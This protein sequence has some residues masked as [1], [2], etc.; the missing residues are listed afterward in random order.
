ML[1]LS[2]YNFFMIKFGLEKEAVSNKHWKNML[3]TRQNHSAAAKF[4]IL[5]GLKDKKNRNYLLSQNLQK[6]PPEVF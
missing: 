1:Q 4:K 2:C 6:Q 5:K 3:V